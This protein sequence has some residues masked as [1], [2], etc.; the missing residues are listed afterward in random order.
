MSNLKIAKNYSP[1]VRSQ[2]WKTAVQ[3]Q[4]ALSL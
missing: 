4:V 2:S 1:M 3:K